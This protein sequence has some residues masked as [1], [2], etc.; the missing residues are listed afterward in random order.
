M[1]KIVFA[2]FVLVLLLCFCIYNWW[3]LR[4]RSKRMFE[5]E[6]KRINTF[7]THTAWGLYALLIFLIILSFTAY[8]IYKL[9]TYIQ[10]AA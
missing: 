10:S 2:L 8:E 5:E 7:N 1:G 6:K 3:E 9:M 4:E